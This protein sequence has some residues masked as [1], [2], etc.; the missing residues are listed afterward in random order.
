MHTIPHNISIKLE[1][2]YE[3]CSIQ[4][5][6]HVGTPWLE[7]F[8]SCWLER[9]DGSTLG[10]CTNL[11]FVKFAEELDFHQKG[12]CRLELTA[13]DDDDDAKKTLLD[14]GIATGFFTRLGG[15]LLC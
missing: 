13:N 10:M 12:R 9:L 3:E 6:R 8:F 4:V 5:Y 15:K 11:Q 1:P 7:M 2:E 14:H